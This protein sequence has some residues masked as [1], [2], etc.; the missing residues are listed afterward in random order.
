[1]A[2]INN[3]NNQNNQNNQNRSRHNN[4]RPSK[5]AK[6]RIRRRNI[7]FRNGYYMETDPLSEESI[8]HRNDVLKYKISNLKFLKRY[9]KTYD[10]N[11]IL[12]LSDS[13]DCFWYFL[14]YDEDVKDHLRGMNREIYRMFPKILK[15]NEGNDFRD[16]IHNFL[17][18]PCKIFL[19]FDNTSTENYFRDIFIYKTTYNG[20]T[21]TMTKIKRTKEE[22]ST[23][24]DFLFS[25]FPTKVDFFICGNESNVLFYKPEELNLMI[26]IT[27]KYFPITMMDIQR[28]LCTYIT[29]DSIISSSNPFIHSE[30]YYIQMLFGSTLQCDMKR[31]NSTPLHNFHFNLNSNKKDFPNYIKRIPN[32]LP[33]PPYSMYTM[34]KINSV[35]RIFMLK[36]IYREY[37]ERVKQ[38]KH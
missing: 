24:V 36:D 17:N 38:F 26:K 3:R 29:G 6:N 34:F 32:N 7:T 31:I 4:N 12:N 33:E 8:Y 1:M 21:R 30:F 37:I 15:M 27:N 19:N 22:Q 5:S 2:S 23:I 18:K 11:T 28:M 9:K 35:K 20:D 25:D 16:Y 14:K 13:T 10:P